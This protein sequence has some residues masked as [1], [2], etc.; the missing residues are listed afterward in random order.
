MLSAVPLHRA[1]PPRQRMEVDF[2]L[3]IKSH[4]PQELAQLILQC[5]AY[6]PTQRPSFPQ[7]RQALMKARSRSRLPLPRTPLTLSGK[8]RWRTGRAGKR[9]PAAGEHRPACLA[10]V[11]RG[12]TVV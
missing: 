2:K 3:M 11:A 4:V 6:E 10:G 1:S 5:T 8:H 12:C 9:A 7:I